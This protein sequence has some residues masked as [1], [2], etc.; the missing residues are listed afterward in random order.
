MIVSVEWS[1]P[2]DALPLP[3]SEVHVWRMNLAE[4]L[5]PDARATLSADEE[6]RARQFRFPHLTRRFVAARA[7]LRAILGRYTGLEPADLE[8]TYAARG[9]PAL[10][11]MV[12]DRPLAFNVSHSCD[13]GLC[14][15]TAGRDVGVDVEWRHEDRD[16]FDALETY[17]SAAECATLRALD[18]RAR[19]AACYACWTRKEAFLKARG[20]GLS[21]PLDAFDV[22]CAPGEPARILGVRGPAA[23]RPRWTV[24]DIEPMAGWAGAVVIEGDAVPIRR[25]QWTW[26]F[27]GAQEA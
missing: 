26:P 22:S 13:L 23:D 10:A 7:A 9:K 25:W 16:L 27:P 12:P 3:R 19:R 17:F 2:P 6:D 20:D 11:S 8:F 14:A 24:F 15:V 21:I 4:A 5:P 18:P 1:M